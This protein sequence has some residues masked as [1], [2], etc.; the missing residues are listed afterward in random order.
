MPSK[1]KCTGCKKYFPVEQL[2]QRPAGRFH[3]IECMIEYAARNTKKLAQKGREIKHKNLKVNH[4]KSDLK[5]RKEAAK[6]ACHE[7]IR[8]R[9]RGK[10]CIC[11]DRPLGDNYHAGHFHPSGSN[12][13]TRYD[14]DNIMGQ[15]IDCNYFKGGDSGS[16]RENLEKRIGEE[17]V[18]RLDTLKDEPIKWTV[19]ELK[20]IELYYKSK[21]KEL[22]QEN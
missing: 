6:K 10:N 20:R 9:D 18:L 7:Y 5:I 16:Y 13:Y 22:Q 14:E 12:P 1:G 3:S 17:R 19:E 21:I 15:R 8:M 4:R 11:C 2:D